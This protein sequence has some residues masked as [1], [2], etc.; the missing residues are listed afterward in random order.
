[1]FVLGGNRWNSQ[2][3]TKVDTLTKKGLCNLPHQYPAP[4]P[5]G[6]I[7]KYFCQRTI[8]STLP[9][10]YPLMRISSLKYMIHGLTK[11]YLKADIH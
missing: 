10:S 4:L 5:I 1:M 6:L 8:I 9:N 7:G 11:Q 3:V 2:M